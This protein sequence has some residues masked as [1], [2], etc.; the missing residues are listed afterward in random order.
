M[1]VMSLQMAK[2]DFLVIGLSNGQFCGWNLAANSF[3][4]LQAH[5]SSVNALHF[6]DKMLISGAA[7]DIQVRETDGF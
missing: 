6:A 3:D 4:Q 5:G 7:N 2:P 1:P